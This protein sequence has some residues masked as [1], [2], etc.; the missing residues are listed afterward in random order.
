MLMNLGAEG[1]GIPNHAALACIS[2]PLSK[3]S[4]FLTRSSA[5][6]CEMGVQSVH[7]LQVA[8]ARIA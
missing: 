8:V 6:S 7:V 1:C 2:T 4:Q 5:A 3:C